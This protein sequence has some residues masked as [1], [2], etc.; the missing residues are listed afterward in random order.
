MPAIPKTPPGLSKSQRRKWREE[1]REKR[2]KKREQ[3]ERL[4]V[5]HQIRLD[6]EQNREPSPPPP[7]RVA[8]PRYPS[9]FGAARPESP[10]MSQS[11]R[12]FSP[13]ASTRSSHG[14]AARWA[15]RWPGAGGGDSSSSDDEFGMMDARA[16]AARAL[17]SSDVS[18]Y[19]HCFT[20]ICG[21]N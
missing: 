11:R 20:F 21:L 13:A 1:Q 16:A 10:K 19:Y 3:D 2:E 6:R 4:K 8:L 7:I 17:K 12:V 9:P 15:A 5:L 18:S 14:P